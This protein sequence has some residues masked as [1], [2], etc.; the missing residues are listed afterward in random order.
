MAPAACSACA[1][2]HRPAFW[3]ARDGHQSEISDAAGQYG[4]QAFLEA[5][6][7]RRAPDQSMHS[8]RQ[9]ASLYTFA[10]PVLLL[11]QD[12]LGRKLGRGPDHYLQ[13]D[14]QIGQCPL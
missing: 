7:Q 5:G 8:M 1:T 9:S 4:K 10:L 2:P 11:R 13:V 14:E 3:S 6:G 12:G